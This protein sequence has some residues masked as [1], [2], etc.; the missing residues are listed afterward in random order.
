MAG[1]KIKLGVIRVDGERTRNITVYQGE[2]IVGEIKINVNKS[3]IEEKI[4]N[5]L[6][7]LEK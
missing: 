1:D 5:L 2:E 4:L 7:I 3:D 6:K